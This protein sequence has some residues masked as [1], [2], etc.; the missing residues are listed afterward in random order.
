M[1]TGIMDWVEELLSEPAESMVCEDPW[2]RPSRRG[3]VMTMAVCWGL[4]CWSSTARRCW[5]TS[6]RYF[7]SAELAFS[8]AWARISAALVTKSVTAALRMCSGFRSSW[9]TYDTMKRWAL[10]LRWGVGTQ[11]CV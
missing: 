11:V 10:E 3:S 1:S 7:C 8:S 6:S 5:S 4:C 9:H 2:C